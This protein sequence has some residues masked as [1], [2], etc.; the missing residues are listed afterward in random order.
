MFDPV[1]PGV[2]NH[3]SE[4]EKKNIS[5]IAIDNKR[6]SQ[7]SPENLGLTKKEKKL[8]KSEEKKLKQAK[9]KDSRGSLAVQVHKV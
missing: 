7:E 2:Q 5:M 3:I 1:S 8:M 4:F 9:N 6:K